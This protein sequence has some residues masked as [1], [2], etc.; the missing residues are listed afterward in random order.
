MFSD[1]NSGRLPIWVT[2]TPQINW[3]FIQMYNPSPCLYSTAT[4]KPSSYRQSA[5][6]LA[7]WCTHWRPPCATRS[8]C[9]AS[10]PLA[11][12]RTQAKS[13]HTTTTTRRAPSSPPNGRSPIS[14]LLSSDSSTRCIRRDYWSSLCPTV[15][16]PTAAAASSSSDAFTSSTCRV[17][18]LFFSQTNTSYETGS[19]FISSRI[20][21]KWLK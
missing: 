10:G 2:C 20:W 1:L 15:L 9:T 4:G 7:S 19:L 11:G 16:R 12:T 13:C 21:R 8:T 5:W 17:L 14:C 6:A 3:R 18:E